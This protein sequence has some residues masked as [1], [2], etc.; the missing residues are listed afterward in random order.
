MCNRCL[1]ALM[2][3]S[4][5]SRP[6]ADARTLRL[7]AACEV[8]GRDRAAAGAVVW[9][10]IICKRQ[11]SSERLLATVDVTDLEAS[12]FP[13]VCVGGGAHQDVHVH[14]ICVEE[15][16]RHA[17]GQPFRIFSISSVVDPQRFV[18]PCAGFAAFS[19]LS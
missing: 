13:R 2:H 5:C 11:C 7:V 15:L 6:G 16:R 4:M 19:G 3:G 9:S 14:A 17:L 18:D 8:T 12:H 10:A 1:H